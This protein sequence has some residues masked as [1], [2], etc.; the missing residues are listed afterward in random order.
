MQQQQPK[1]I[2][3]GGTL[4]SVSQNQIQ[5]STNTNQKMFVMIR[6]E[7]EVSVTGTA[8]QD[9][10]KSGVNVEF[11]AEVDKTHTVK[12]K[13]VKL[14]I[15][16]PTTER[17]AG[18]F[19]PDL[20]TPSKSE[21]GENGGDGVKP[22]PHDPGIGDAP[23][24]KGRKAGGKKEPDLF[25]ADPL[26]SKPAKTRSSA[27]QFPG[28]FTVRGAIKMCKDG[29]ITVSAGRGPTIKAELASDATIDVEMSDLRAATRRPGHGGRFCR[30]PTGPRDGQV[31]YD[32]IG[33]SVV[34]GEE[35]WFAHQA[36]A[37]HAP[38]A[39]KDA[40]DP[41]NLLK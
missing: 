17:P 39:K 11:V 23:P 7:T 21:K 10:L 33:Q 35:T 2:K 41:D 16:S 14:L 37:A 29:K 13:I 5:L 26:A 34:R 9:Y 24:P 40:A 6:P 19:A 3:A 30:G 25:G 4:V 36:P 18:L 22:L 38:K 8:E 28:T 1:P 15:V 27:P 31:G 32:R 12:E 20:A